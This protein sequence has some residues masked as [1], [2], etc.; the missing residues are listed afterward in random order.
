LGHKQSQ[1]STKRRDLCPEMPKNSQQIVIAFNALLLT[2]AP[3]LAQSGT[4]VDSEW[5]QFTPLETRQD[6]ADSVRSDVRVPIIMTPDAIQMPSPGNAAEL[7][8]GFRIGS[9]LIEP[10]SQID[11]TLFEKL[12]EPYLGAEASSEDFTRL[13][14]EIA[15]VA[16]AQGMV[17]ASAHIPPQKI[18]LGILRVVLTIGVI[19]EVRIEGSSNRALQK[20]FAPLVGQVVLQKELERRLMLSNDIPAITAKQA[21]FIN[22]D[23]RCILVVRVEERPETSGQVSLDNSGSKRVGPLRGRLKFDALSV[24]EASDA[25]SATIQTNPVDPNELRSA[26]LA[27]SIGLNNRGTRA[28]VIVAASKSSLPSR[29]D[30]SRR[31]IT[32][33][34]V[35][36]V[37][38]HPLRRLRGSNAWLESQLEY[39]EIEQESLGALIA[40]DTVVTL[41]ASL[42]TSMNLA[43]GWLRSGLQVR[44]GLEILGAS[45]PG[46]LTSSRYDADGQFT[47]A[48]AWINWSGKPAGDFTVSL[49]MTGQLANAP[50][51]PA[52][53]ISLGGVYFGRGFEPYELS[54]DQ[55]VIASA[56]LGYE[57]ANPVDWLDRLQPY[58][59]VDGGYIDWLRDATG[60]GGLMSSGGG[61]RAEIGRV[62]FQ[63]ETAVPVSSSGPGEP[64]N[65]PKLNFQLGVS[66]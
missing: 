4:G 47:S 49:A 23:G 51:L 38:N 7:P 66:F 65:E 36:A 10:S 37:I 19:D 5:R 13:T 57:Y 43:D 59:F 46:S 11:H 60:G 15:A 45:Q 16:R 18:E 33:Q 30:F 20:L 22:E 39:L 27:Y 61:F 53:Q 55:G 50:L 44:Q 41:S 32:S 58:A 34:Y 63:V 8:K 29:M 42:A 64:K 2:G 40:S 24:F 21:E 62:G 9:V 56:E 1:I 17:L 31:D 28:G 52:E 12:I 6:A 54:G 14:E 48:R 3:A 35:S 25:V 26:S